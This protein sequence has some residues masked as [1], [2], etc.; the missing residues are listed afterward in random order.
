M[1]SFMLAVSVVS[2]LL[3][4]MLVGS[5]IKKKHWFS[6][7]Q[8]KALNGVIFKIFLPLTLFFDVYKADLE[9]A[10]QKEVFSFVVFAVL[11]VYVIV[12]CIAARLIKDKAD[13]ST[14]IQGI[15]R[16]NFVL[17]GNS[18]A[19]SMCDSEGKAL[20]AA[21]AAVIVPLYNILAVI[22]FESMRGGKVKLTEI[23]LNIIKNPLVEAGIW[24]ILCNV[25]N[26]KF[27]EW[28]MTPFVRMGDIATP[29]ALVTLGG[30]LSFD[31]IV[32]HKKY[33]AAAVPGRLVIVPF[34]VI[35]AAILFGFRGQTLIVFLS[36][37][38]APTAVASSP[39]A[40]SMGGN[41]ELAG[42]IVAISSAFSVVTIFLFV[43]G[44]SGLGLV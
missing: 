16:S 7:E 39:M 15:Y 19:F 34:S 1:E 25:L 27:P 12:W 20:V 37:F 21:M 43:F 40:Q 35:L 2:P 36:I 31:S 29:L 5:F 4:Y 3:I 10:L 14:L 42:E 44:L 32:K 17:F 33:L 22:L 30:M 28:L 13:A 8:F 6:K 18:I 23:L 26:V 9:A 24:G 41:G 38:A 11:A